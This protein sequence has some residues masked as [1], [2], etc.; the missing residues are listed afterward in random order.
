MFTLNDDLS[1]YATRGDVVFFDL[2]ADKDGEEYK[3]QAGDVVRFKVYGKKNAEEVL[4]QKD[5]GVE[6]ETTTV[7]IML[8]KEDTK[9][10]EVISKPKDYWYE[11]E[12]NPFTEP[13][14]LV[15]YDEDGPKV[16]K[17]FPE[18]DDVPEF[19][20]SPEDV[21]VIDTELDMTSTRPV[22]NQAIARA[23]VKLNADFKTLDTYAKNRFETIRLITG[24]TNEAVQVQKARLDLALAGTTPEGS[25]IVDV[26]VGYDGKTYPSSGAA[27]RGQVSEIVNNLDKAGI[28]EETLMEGTDNPGYYV[29]K[30]S[31]ALAFV[32]NPNRGY[33]AY[34]VSEY[35]GKTLLISTALDIDTI[36][37]YLF[38]DA[39]NLPV[40]NLPG[41]SKIHKLAVQVPNGATV[42]YVNY[43]ANEVAR[44]NV[45]VKCVSTM[46][47][48]AEIERVN[49]SIRVS[50]AQFA[51]F[52][53][54][55]KMPAVLTWELGWIDYTNGI[56][57]VS[58]YTNRMRTVGYYK[59]IMDIRYTVPAGYRFLALRYRDG[60]FVDSTGY[61]NGAKSGRIAVND[62]D[63]FRFLLRANPDMDLTDDYKY[64]EI[65]CAPEMKEVAT[66]PAYWEDTLA[67]KETEIKTIIHDAAKREQDVAVFMAIADPHY[68]GN[69][70][71]SAE[72]MKH[73][74]D[75]CGISVT[76]C[77]GD[78]M[79]DSTVSHEEGLQRIQDGMDKLERMSRRP[80]LTQGNHDTNVQIVDKN[81]QLMADRIIYDR[82]WKLHTNNRLEN[83]MYDALGKAFYYDDHLQRIR[84]ISLDSFE[85]KKYTIADGV[86]T[87]LSLGDI[88]AR[89]V[90]WLKNVLSTVP[91]G[92]SVV[93]FSHYGIYQPYVFDGE[94]YVS[95]PYGATRNAE[96][97][98]ALK[99]CNSFIGHFAGHLHKDFVSK[100]DG[101]VS[102]HLLN[103]GNDHR[104]ATYFGD[105]SFV[106][107]APVKTAGTTT[108]CA[109]DVVVVNKSTRHVDLIRI[110][111]GENRVFDY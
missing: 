78:L 29:A 20:P 40:A 5:F 45:S 79:M 63:S 96:V 85:G 16:F 110:G 105:Y 90:I 1:I 8:T 74:A 71:I 33:F 103:D 25:E 61:I 76:L 21:S 80:L 101:L 38:A 27:A 22:Q 48:P 87:N 35:A 19:E 24:A 28:Y 93:T 3:F 111:A 15:G 99:E 26:R 98:A 60:V 66:I 59:P 37:V 67:A 14:T 64:L 41:L 6:T 102:V 95:I 47:V 55:G 84:F 83:V 17:L 52:V 58:E 108:E 69:T 75:K 9:I 72:L 2:T 18:G 7:Q 81:G 91:S 46:D 107:D 57:G 100:K 92:Y 104:K 88:T 36:S 54:D 34:D 11:V 43:A 12:L 70:G 31:G 51:G 42:L 30:N 86:L 65:Y 82:E 94:K 77:L 32:D 23:V 56:D 10:G 68:P 97:A 49:E 44:D 39:E 109:F 50:N 4:L 62:G 89:Q 53:K 106:G 73:L 13:Q